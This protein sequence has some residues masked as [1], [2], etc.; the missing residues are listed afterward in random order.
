MEGGAQY[1][2]NPPNEI[3][4][5]IKKTFLSKTWSTS[6]LLIV[7]SDNKS[8]TCQSAFKIFYQYS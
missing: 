1:I 2:W 6:L 8:I 7:I 5:L 4:I 3:T